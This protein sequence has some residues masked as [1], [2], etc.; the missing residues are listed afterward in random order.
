MEQTYFEM[1]SGSKAE[2]QLEPKQETIQR[3]LDYSRSL[4]VID[5]E[6]MQIDCILN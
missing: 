5:T 1:P 4:K 2:K 6:H 3:I